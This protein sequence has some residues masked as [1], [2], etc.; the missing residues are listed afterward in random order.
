MEIITIFRVLK[1]ENFT[2][3]DVIG[4]LNSTGKSTF[5]KCQN[6]S[7]NIEGAIN[8]RIHTKKFADQNPKNHLKV[9]RPIIF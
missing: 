7:C 4:F 6:G 2:R 3:C 1:G 8:V 5:T 9:Q